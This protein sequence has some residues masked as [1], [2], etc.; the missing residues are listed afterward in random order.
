[1]KFLTIGAFK[2]TWYTQSQ[3]ERQ[4][5]AVSTLEADFKLKSE[6][7]DKFHFYNV[8]GRD[9]MAVIISEVNSLE[10]LA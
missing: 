2:D 5:L 3:A 4:K 10:E 9:Y 7:G 6:M 8:P 1:M